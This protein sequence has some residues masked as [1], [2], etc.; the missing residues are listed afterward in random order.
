MKLPNVDGYEIVRFVAAGGMCFVYE[1]H[2]P[3]QSQPV[4]IKILHD[5]WGTDSEVAQRFLN[6][7]RALQSLRHPNLV[8]WLDDGALPSGQPYVVLEWLP[9]NVA[10]IVDKH[11]QGIATDLV[12]RVATHLARALVFLHGERIFH[13][14]VKSANVLLSGDDLQVAEVRLGDLNLSKVAREHR[15]AEGMNISTAGGKKLGTDDFM[16]PEQWL[17]SKTVDGAADVYSLG[18]L[19]FQMTTGTLPF[20]AND[21]KSRMAMH[22]FKDPPLARLRGRAS[23]ALSE[24]IALMLRKDAKERPTMAAVLERLETMAQTK[25]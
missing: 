3:G 15:S 2:V 8:T 25:G 20:V 10:A 24:L 9:S 19:L 18:V 7:S 6:E 16:A 23:P 21:A 22:L 14:D 11:P 13:R 4:A 5:M 1:A 12:L 17:K